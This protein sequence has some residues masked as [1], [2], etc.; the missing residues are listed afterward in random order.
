MSTIFKSIKC[1]SNITNE[2]KFGLTG[3]KT[4][5]S[6]TAPSSS[7]TLTIPDTKTNS[8]FITAHSTQTLPSL[9]NFTGDVTY[10]SLTYS[11]GTA[12]QTTFTITG[13]GTT[14]T[15]AMVGGYILWTSGSSAIITS[16]V[17]ATQ[18]TTSNSQAV[19][20]GAYV[21][22]YSGSYVR[23][24]TTVL[25]KSRLYGQTALGAYGSDALTAANLINLPQLNTTRIST[26]AL[27][28]SGSGS[29]VDTTADRI[30]YAPSSAGIAIISFEN[31]TSPQLLSTAT[32]SAQGFYKSRIMGN[33]LYGITFTTKIFAIWDVSNLKNP[34]L[35]SNLTFAGDTSAFYVRGTVAYILN[36][37]G[38]IF[39]YECIDPS[40]P[41]LIN[42][43][44]TGQSALTA[45]EVKGNYLYLGDAT[46]GLTIYDV[47]N[48]YAPIKYTA[49]AVTG[50]ISDFAIC[51]N[52]L[53]S[54]TG[55]NTNVTVID[56]YNPTAA[57]VITSVP[58]G[59]VANTFTIY[60]C[61]DFLYVSGGASTGVTI[62]D[63]RVPT[64]P[65][66]YSNSRYG[67]LTSINSVSLTGRYLF[68]SNLGSS[69]NGSVDCFDLG[70][71]YSQQSQF[72]SLEVGE[73]YVREDSI[74][75]ANL[76]VKGSLTIGSDIDCKYS[77]SI[78]SSSYNSI[79]SALN[80][81]AVVPYYAGT[82]AQSGT[83][84][85]G[86]STTFTTAM[87]GGT[88]VYDTGKTATI[89][90]FVSTTSLTASVSQTQ[91]LS[92]PYVIYY[93][94]IHIDK[95]GYLSIKKSILT[96]N[97]SVPIVTTIPSCNSLAPARSN[98]INVDKNG[99]NTTGSRA[100]GS[101]FLTLTAALAVA[102]S[103]DVVNVGPGV[104]DAGETYPI[105]IPTNVHVFGKGNV[106]IGGVTTTTRTPIHMSPQSTL[107]DITINNTT[108]T[109][110]LTLNGARFISNAET[111]A[112]L[113]N[114]KINIS[115]SVINTTTT[116]LQGVYF[117]T[118]GTA[119][120]GFMNL[121]NCQV[122]VSSSVTLTG[123]SRIVGLYSDTSSTINVDSNT[124]ITATGTTTG[125]TFA[126]NTVG[127]SSV[128]NVYSKNIRSSGQLF[129]Q[130]SGTI[131]F[132]DDSLLF[133]DVQTSGTNGQ[134]LS[135]GVWNTRTINT[136]VGNGKWATLASD[137]IT[138]SPGI[139][140]LSVYST[141]STSVGGTVR[142]RLR[143]NNITDN[144]FVY[145]NNAYGTSVN[146]GGV[147]TLST[148]ISIS[149]TKVFSID[150][151]S[152]VGTTV[153]SVGVGSGDEIYTSVQIDRKYY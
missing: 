133:Q 120:A 18:L 27:N 113:I 1:T 70:G 37:T 19:L 5:I 35:K 106:S 92:V 17:S 148:P 54:I 73:A 95:S 126:V 26:Y 12:S 36:Y 66:V 33:T 31:P 125:L 21:I 153:A 127:A 151:Y 91:T 62:V 56:I 111:S 82:A 100:D 104:Y 10:N 81:T 69:G 3:N 110:N 77:K 29:I 58:T 20:S 138:L 55:N 123:T 94:G 75:S 144:T 122:I 93:G 23:S 97:T 99:S 39:V 79:S 24:D 108:A 124:S 15:S 6:Y 131:N 52:Y 80:S 129:G 119:P 76:Q 50:G 83:T 116:I 84:I 112:Q 150:V 68:V 47:R 63:V 109:A 140:N 53:Y 96:S 146:D 14:F 130:T 59:A 86:T 102:L 28:V 136:K 25:N 45:V 85:T 134:T 41:V 34:I 4:T 51:N 44:A 11:T 30:V 141:V 88:I 117:S 132:L 115:N 143:L 49:V 46:A 71:I 128:I 48:Q 65:V 107:N 38:S 149:T 87:V 2:L 43:I 32:Y 90:A 114:C 98:T 7:I 60:S 118:T 135:G 74:F 101:P 72:G 9:K 22:Y 145:G 61:G 57:A 139:Y 152:T 105:V 67:S 78:T 137:Q 121:V 42:T 103:G 40:T 147:S 8:S 142:F 89:V 64:A 16:F 13:S